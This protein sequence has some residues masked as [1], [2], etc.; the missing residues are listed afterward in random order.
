ML[1]GYYDWFNQQS[2]LPEMLRGVIQ[3]GQGMV[4]N[5]RMEQAHWASQKT[6]M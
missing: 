2:F 6:L 3:G 1:R 4:A 5:T